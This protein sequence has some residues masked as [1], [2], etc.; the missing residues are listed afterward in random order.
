MQIR[1]AIATVIAVLAQPH[2]RVLELGSGPGL[3]AEQVLTL[4]NVSEY[5][6]FDFSP[7]MLKMARERLQSQSR[8]HYVEGSFKEASWPSLL[9]PPF[10]VVVAQQ[11]LH[12]IRHK[13]HLSG[14]YAQILTVQSPGGLLLVCDHN[15]VDERDQQRGLHASSD[16]QMAFM[17][18]AGFADVQLQNTVHGLYLI[19]AR[20]P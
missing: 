9:S 11:A 16:E 6:L 10:D 3:L 1:E 4:C 8:A 17:R 2:P 12:E 18:D 7:P 19:S 15:P 14:L 5:T 13:R 20:R